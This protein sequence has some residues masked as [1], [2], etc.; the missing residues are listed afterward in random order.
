MFGFDTDDFVAF[1]S[2]FQIEAYASYLLGVG[3][4]NLNLCYSLRSQVPAISRLE[5][6]A[7]QVRAEKERA[8]IP[9]STFQPPSAI[10]MQQLQQQMRLNQ[11]VSLASLKQPPFYRPPG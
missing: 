6:I 1:N 4:E 2:T 10:A 8:L 7:V 3:H 11:P 9:T 5:S